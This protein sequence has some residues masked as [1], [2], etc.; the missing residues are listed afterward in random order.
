MGIVIPRSGTETDGHRPGTATL[1]LVGDQCLIV[2][3]AGM[4]RPLHIGSAVIGL[5]VTGGDGGHHRQLSQDFRQT[6]EEFILYLL[7]A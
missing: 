2:W 5:P 1:G 7:H 3:G 4:T 6:G